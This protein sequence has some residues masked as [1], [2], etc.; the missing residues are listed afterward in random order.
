M[1]AFRT[2]S[3]AL[4]MLLLASPFALAGSAQHASSARQTE[5][6][7]SSQGSGITQ[8]QAM[9]EIKLDGYTDVQ[10]LQKTSKGWTAKAKEGDHQVSLLVD[11]HG[12]VEKT[13]AGS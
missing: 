10:N 11:D 5:S 4:G 3:V 6:H 1:N 8:E 9:R 2:S 7:A 13:R 12:N